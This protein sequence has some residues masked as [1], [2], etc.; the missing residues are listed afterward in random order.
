[1]RCDGRNG[2]GVTDER[3]HDGG[4]LTKEGLY[5]MMTDMVVR[6]RKVDAHERSVLETLARFLKLPPAKA[7][8]IALES[9]RRMEAGDIAAGGPFDAD[10]AYALV[11]EAAA[12]DGKIDGL[13]AKMLQG[14]AL[15]LGI[16][17]EASDG[18][19]PPVDER[20]VFLRVL[21]DE[22][23]RWVE[24]GRLS[25]AEAG[26]VLAAARGEAAPKDAPKG[27]AAVGGMVPPTTAKV[28]A[29]ASP[30]VVYIDDAPDIA[31]KASVMGRLSR[32]L[33]GVAVVLLGVGMFHFYGANWRYMTPEVKLAQVVFVLL[34]LHGGAYWC[35]TR[36]GGQDL[37][38]RA[39]VVL[40]QLS[41]GG[42]L[43]MVAQIYHISARPTNGMLVW[44]VVATAMA[45]VVRER[46]SAYLG[47]AVLLIWTSWEWG[48][49]WSANWWFPAVWLLSVMV[50][51][52][53]EVR[54]G[55]GLCYV[56]LL[57]WIMQVGV[58][59]GHPKAALLA[60]IVVSLDAAALTRESWGVWCASFIVFFWDVAVTG[61]HGHTNLWFPLVALAVGYGFY[62]F[63]SG[64]GMVVLS[65][66]T[67]WW[68]TMVNILWV[69][70][71]EPTA[72]G[73]SLAEAAARN[74]GEAGNVELFRP[75]LNY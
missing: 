65:T 50:F 7:R 28:T 74:L 46:W 5:R 21:A 12:A 58:V 31:Q 22:V 68:A 18:A 43:G 70:H 11:A 8:E 64:G 33:T 27:A 19:E 26:R 69:A 45:W 6:D 2:W 25:E 55:A 72:T 34:A 37:L 75:N 71:H 52:S 15:L 44:G 36:R 1:V 24:A 73:G 40:A 48:E 35:L 9:K 13:E 14:L 23:P 20:Q 66:E 3:K 59:Q 32:M 4:A 56:S 53:L 63:R 41:F 67:V 49:Y 61:E 60:W 29:A 62:L 16:S 10:E 39:L 54:A 47:W 51:R 42:A 57:T 38:G 17:D 30:A